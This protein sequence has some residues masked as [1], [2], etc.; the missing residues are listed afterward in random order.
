[1]YTGDYAAIKIIQNG[2][3]H[4]FQVPSTSDVFSGDL[5]K[6]VPA[7]FPCT[8]ERPSQSIKY[9]GGHAVSATGVLDSWR[10]AYCPFE[11]SVQ[12]GVARVG[13]TTYNP[14]VDTLSATKLLTYENMVGGEDLVA[15]LRLPSSAGAYDLCFSAR[16]N[17]VTANRNT[18]DIPIF[19][20]IFK[21]DAG[22]CASASITNKQDACMPKTRLVV[23]DSATQNPLRWSSPDVL[24][25]GWGVIKVYHPSGAAT[26]SNGPATAWELSATKSHYTTIG[27][28]QFRLVRSTHFASSAITYGD[29]YKEFD[30]TRLQT[31]PQRVTSK[32]ATRVMTAYNRIDAGAESAS[33]GVEFGASGDKLT[34]RYQGTPDMGT[35]LPLSTAG[36]WNRVDDNYGNYNK[37]LNGINSG[38]LTTCCSATS[39]SHYACTST[40]T[41]SMSDSDHEGVTASADL[42]GDPRTSVVPWTISSTSSVS[43]TWAYIRFPIV[44]KWHVCYRVAGTN[45]WRVI[46]SAATGL[47]YFE[48][49]TFPTRNYTYHVNDSQA[50][51]WGPLVVHDPTKGLTNENHN[52]VG[53]ETTIVGASV[54]IVKYTAACDTDAGT[55][56]AFSTKAGNHECEIG[57]ITSG[58]CSAADCLGQADDST[59]ARYEVAFYVR[60]PPYPTSVERVEGAYY[61]VCFR[62]KE[63]SWVQL[64]DPHY[65]RHTYMT[66]PWHFVP[67]PQPPMHFSL[68]DTRAGT[69]AKI[70]LVRTSNSHANAFNLNPNGDVLR[71]VQN[72]TSRGHP[73]H[74]DVTVGATGDFSLQNYDAAKTDADLGLYCRATTSTSTALCYTGTVNP[75]DGAYSGTYPYD[76]LDKRVDGSTIGDYATHGAFATLTI[77]AAPNTLAGYRLCYKP[78]SANWIELPPDWS[79]APNPFTIAARPTHTAGIGGASGGIGTVY[80]GQYGYIA[81]SGPSLNLD[82]DVVK[83]VLSSSGGCDRPAAGTQTPGSKFASFTWR[84]FDYAH[85]NDARMGGAAWVPTSSVSAQQSTT[86]TLGTTSSARA[87][88]TFPTLDSH[89]AATTA[90]K[91]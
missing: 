70:L 56:D 53:T 65:I 68:Q 9:C 51:T 11:G 78:R 16:G 41:C 77:P 54:K 27:G 50:E 6:L 3:R 18:S 32:T 91:I 4:P 8:Y 48:P 35:A 64:Q 87:Y 74:C 20:K 29:M 14:F 72:M 17:R 59:T 86:A 66:S 49:G 58:A 21:R 67:R 79:S 62:N 13:T 57:C 15:Y 88:M 89:M 42:G 76:N 36:C 12:D 34:H 44:G 24:P 85:W 90:Y 69:W 47:D 33:S 81:I 23:T 83:L 22:T 25:G 26:Q 43:A 60:M 46:K 84:I 7:G 80:A 39:G 71:L 1:M 55:A 2:Y 31:V 63:E 45:N 61:R 28:D 52:L 40:T 38:M 82:N 73:V 5:L 30:G 10:G 37:G 19:G 75:T